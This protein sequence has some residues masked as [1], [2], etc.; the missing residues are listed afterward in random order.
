MK[1]GEK[2]NNCVII[3]V[4]NES[5]KGIMCA[6]FPMYWNR[7]LNYA[8]GANFK[9][10]QKDLAKFNDNNFSDWRLPTQKELELIFKLKKKIKNVTS[11]FHMSSE[12]D[13]AEKIFG[14]ALVT[15]HKSSTSLKNPCYVHP[16]REFDI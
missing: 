14:T 8:D 1:P 11:G 5:K 9:K 10:A 12:L 3:H 16:V 15:G 4:D 2:I 13:G 7:S 6:E